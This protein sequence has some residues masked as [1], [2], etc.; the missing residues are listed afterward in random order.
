MLTVIGTRGD[1]YAFLMTDDVSRYEWIFLM[2]EKATFTSGSNQ[3]K[4]YKRVNRIRTDNEFA[5]NYD[6]TLSIT[7]NSY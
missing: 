2:N 1:R 3:S 5:N 4:H 6:E 7:G